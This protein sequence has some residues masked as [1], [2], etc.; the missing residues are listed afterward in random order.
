MADVT[1]NASVLYESGSAEKTVLYL[2]KNVDTSDTIDVSAKFS[3]V[4]SA[5]S[6]PAGGLSTGDVCAVAS[7]VVTLDVAAATDDTL[8]VLVVGDSAV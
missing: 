8:F 2:V 7:L 1:A 3:K 6:I 4:K 5:V